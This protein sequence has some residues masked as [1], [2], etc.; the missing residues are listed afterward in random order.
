MA[1]TKGSETKGQSVKGTLER[2]RGRLD[3]CRAVKPG[4]VD[5]HLSGASGG[6]YRISSRA[7]KTAISSAVAR[8]AGPA[9]LVEIWGDSDTICAIIEGKKDP[10]RQFLAGGIRVRGNLRY[11]SDVAVELGIL[12]KPL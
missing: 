4:S 9:P 6:E 2:L 8:E 1:E 11:F 5:L 12:Q 10:V 3:K 7:G